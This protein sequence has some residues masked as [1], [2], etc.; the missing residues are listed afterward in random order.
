MQIKNYSALDFNKVMRRLNIVIP[1]QQAKMTPPV[2]PILGQVKI[3]IKDFCA[4]FNESTVNYISG[5]PLRVIVFVFKNETFNFLIQMPSLG[6][7]IKNQ[8]VNS[9]RKYLTLLD[10]YKIALIKNL[11]LTSKDLS[12]TYRNV[13]FYVKILKISIRI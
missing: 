9:K 8:L 6:F 4:S 11:D 2:G 13:L 10:I 5:L 12:A 7:L 1:A 3:K